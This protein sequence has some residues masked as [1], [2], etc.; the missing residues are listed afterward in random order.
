MKAQGWLF[1][2]APGLYNQLSSLCDVC[3]VFIG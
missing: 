1:A 2:P 3:T